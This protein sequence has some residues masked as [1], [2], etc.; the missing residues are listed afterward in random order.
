[1]F[2]NVPWG[3]FLGAIPPF[4][5]VLGYYLATVAVLCAVG[6]EIF[7]GMLRLGAGAPACLTMPALVTIRPI[8]F[9]PFMVNAGLRLS[10]ALVCWHVYA[11]QN[12]PLVLGTGCVLAFLSYLV[13]IH[14]F[15]LVPLVALPLMPYRPL[16][17]K[18]VARGA[19]ALLIRAIAMAAIFDARK[20]QRKELEPFNQLNSARAAFTDFG[21]NEEL[22]Q[23]PDI[24]ERHGFS[25][26]DVELVSTWFF[27]DTSIAGPNLLRSMLSELG[28]LP[29]G[30]NSWANAWLTLKAL[31]LPEIRPLLA[32]ALI[33][34]LLRPGYGI[35]A[36]WLL[37]LAA[38]I[39]MGVLG[40]PG[41]LRVYVPP[42]SLLAVAPFLGDKAFRPLRPLAGLLLATAATI[43]GAAA[44]EN[45]K[46]FE[47]AAIEDR[48]KFAA[49]P[50]KPV[51]IW[52]ASFPF[53][54]ICSVLGASP[55][56]MT[57]SLYGLGVST[58][59][60]F[61]VAFAE[62]K[63]QRGVV[64]RLRHSTGMPFLANEMEYVFS[65]KYCSDHY[66]GS[67]KEVSALTL[68]DQRIS[69]R[70]CSETNAI[71]LSNL[72]IKKYEN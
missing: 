20:Y 56:A 54:R 33:L 69:W 35:A 48:R 41:I 7:H 63:R 27:V 9:Q 43:D 5:R 25:I 50:T 34:A 19:L 53:E 66:G 2:S 4:A 61:S 40:R 42:I 29:A 16:W 13:R 1:M 39:I 67:L 60:P 59:A 64:D 45:S 23:H 38:I 15:L 30:S 52:G 44:I 68:V 65:G 6:A 8:L 46:N 51:V 62:Q 72:P 21:A 70:K 32:V 37:F 55:A 17:R 26:N 12:S 22:K 71:P 58:W 49:F 11:R 3:Y 36:S 57:Y 31:W 10:A 24:L 28:V 47:L 18:P 14:E